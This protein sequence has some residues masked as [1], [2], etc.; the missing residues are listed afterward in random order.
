V[1]YVHVETEEIYNYILKARQTFLEPLRAVS[2]K[3]E[4]KLHF[5]MP[6]ICLRGIFILLFYSRIDRLLAI[7][8]NKLSRDFNDANDY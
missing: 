6:R 2:R 8:R 4:K 7:M 1:C 5:T 3:V